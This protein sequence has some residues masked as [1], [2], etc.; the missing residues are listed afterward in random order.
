MVSLSS[1]PGC[2]V[3]DIQ[4][5]FGEPFHVQI[6]AQDAEPEIPVAVRAD[7]AVVR[8]GKSFPVVAF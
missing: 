1:A 2:N 7:D 5:A 8:N 4:T 3:H 6:F